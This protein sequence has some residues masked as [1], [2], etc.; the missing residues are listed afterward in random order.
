[1]ELDHVFLLVADEAEAERVAQAVGLRETYRRHHRGQGTQNLCCCLDDAFVELLWI[2]DEAEARSPSIARTRLWERSRWRESMSCPFG[3][4][5]RGEANTAGVATWR[6][7]PPYLPDGMAIAIAEASDDPAMPLAF[8]S[9]GREPPSAW[10]PSRRGELQRAVGLRRLDHLRLVAPRP[11][12]PDIARI[13]QRLAIR[14][15]AGAAWSLEVVVQRDDGGLHRFVL[16]TSP[17]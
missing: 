11:L 1:M 12:A 17:H 15:E 16:P 7:T 2:A 10:L 4:A 8:A 9:P 6:Y 3:F 14:V 5:W 13:A